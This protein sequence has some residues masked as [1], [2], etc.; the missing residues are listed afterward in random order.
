MNCLAFT[1]VGEAAKTMQCQYGKQ[2]VWLAI[3]VDYKCIVSGANSTLKIYSLCL[4]I[5]NE[6]EL[7]VEGSTFLGRVE[8]I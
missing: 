2:H 3:A 7:N 1:H 6:S 8:H 5:G 4:E